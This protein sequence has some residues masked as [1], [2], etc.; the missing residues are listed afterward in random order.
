MKKTIF[1]I[2]LSVLCL[3]VQA[4]KVSIILAEQCV[5]NVAGKK[6]ITWKVMEEC[7]VLVGVKIRFKV[8][9][10]TKKNKSE[11][12]EVS[13]EGSNELEKKLN[14]ISE[15]VNQLVLMKQNLNSEQADSL[16]RVVSDELIG[17]VRFKSV[18]DAYTNSSVIDNVQVEVTHTSSILRIYLPSSLLEGERVIDFYTN[19]IQ[20]GNSIKTDVVITRNKIEIYRVENNNVVVNDADE[21]QELQL[22]LN[23]TFKK[24]NIEFYYNPK[25]K[26]TILKYCFNSSKH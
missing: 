9:F 11:C 5:N 20:E 17:G 26:D 15:I 7:D 25:T 3:S 8:G 12:I 13:C 18:I 21:L 1:Q 23:D 22:F 24:A 4:E 16:S 19:K 10:K 14:G 6:Q 2:I